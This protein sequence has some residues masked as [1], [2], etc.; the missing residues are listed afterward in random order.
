[1]GLDAN[2]LLVMIEPPVELMLMAVRNPIV[3]VI[4]LPARDC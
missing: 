4:W 3:Y 1:M 2:N